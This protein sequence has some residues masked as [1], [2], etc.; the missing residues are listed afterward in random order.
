MATVSFSRHS[1]AGTIRLRISHAGS[2]RFVSLGIQVDKDEWSVS[3]S[4]ARKSHSDS[5]AINQRLTEIERVARGVITRLESRPEPVTADWIKDELL[6]ELHG[7]ED[8]PSGFVEFAEAFVEDYRRRGQMGTYRSYA[9]VLSKFKCFL[10]T[11]KGRASLSFHRLNG[12]LIRS[13]RTFCYEVRDNSPN[14]VGKALNVMRTMTRAA[15]EDGHIDRSDYAFEHI[16]IDSEEVQKEKLTPAE[17]NDLAQVELDEDSTAADCRR[18]FLFAYYTG[19]MRF[20]DVATLRPEHIREPAEGKRKRIYYRMQKV[21]NSLGVPLTDEAEEILRYYDGPYDGG[22]VFPILDGVQ[23]DS[24][25]LTARKEAQTSK[26]NNYLKKIAKKAG[27]QKNV[28]FHLSRNAAAW[29]LYQEIGDIY[30]VSKL[31]GHSSVAQ[32]EEY[33][34]GFEDDSLD[35]DFLSA[36]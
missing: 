34:Q 9:S 26:T 1:D 16:A 13:F 17:I 7:D 23:P 30:K 8:G 5:E 33:L 28:T 10:E 18:W 27:L 15:M 4:R 2:R 11:E 21:D 3:K 22:W 31:L 12:A 25:R 32:T 6:S 35:E 19:G 24:S 14:T 29:R 36:F 20:G